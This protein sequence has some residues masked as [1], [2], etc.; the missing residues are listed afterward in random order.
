MLEVA[1]ML[2]CYMLLLLV[3]LGTWNMARLV[4]CCVAS[5]RAGTQDDSEINS[6]ELT[7]VMSHISA[8]LLMSNASLGACKRQGQA[9]HDEAEINSAG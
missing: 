5:G 7:C 9:S 2:C 4:R 3:E 8:Y 6:A 1:S